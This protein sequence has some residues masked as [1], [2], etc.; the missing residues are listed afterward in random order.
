MED[1]E[2]VAVEACRTAGDYLASRFRDAALEAEF[3]TTDVKAA[4]DREAEQR[5]LR[6][7][8]AEFP[9]HRVVAEEDGESGTDDSYTWVVDPLD[10]TNNFVS[11]V[12]VF[13]TAVAVLDAEGP[14]LSVIYEPLPDALYVATPNHLHHPQTQAELHPGQKPQDSKS[15]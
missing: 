14:F 5:V 15:G 8:R 6:E 10:G 3:D 9:D 13:A 11:G 2:S 4:V 12:S 1:M 7:I